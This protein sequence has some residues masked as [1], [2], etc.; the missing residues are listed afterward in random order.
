M[1]N[2]ISDSKRRRLKNVLGAIAKPIPNAGA[3]AKVAVAAGAMDGVAA[4]AMDGVAAG[5]IEG[6]AAGAIDGVAEGPGATHTRPQ[7]WTHLKSLFEVSLFD[8]S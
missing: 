7:I 1:L 5:T 2:L 3:G 6:K 4:G 8:V